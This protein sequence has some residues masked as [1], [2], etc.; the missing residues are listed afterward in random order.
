MSGQF[1]GTLL[2]NQYETQGEIFVE[3]LLQPLL[4]LPA[5]ESLN[6]E[7]TEHLLQMILP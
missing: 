5:I 2:Y 3:E 1:T 6:H 4:G 7:L